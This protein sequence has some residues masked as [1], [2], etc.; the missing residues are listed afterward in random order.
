MHKPN[1][2]QD[3]GSDAGTANTNKTAQHPII[4][5]MEHPEFTPE[6]LPELWKQTK[7]P[8]DAHGGQMVAWGAGVETLYRRC[9]T[10]PQHTKIAV[11]L[12]GI[13]P[14]AWH[15]HTPW[16]D[17]GWAV[18]Q[19]DDL[20]HQATP[21]QILQALAHEQQHP[22]G[23]WRASDHILMWA[24]V[25]QLTG[26]VIEQLPWKNQLLDYATT[27]EQ[28]QATETTDFEQVRSRRRQHIVEHIQQRLLGGDN[29]AWTVFLGIV[30]PGAN[31]GDTAEIA[32]AVE[33]GRRPCLHKA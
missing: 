30:E 7:G 21:E 28:N 1:Q 8:D 18:A 26:P 27:A 3:P 17:T 20:A 6:Q 29:N 11:I 24:T 32:K 2:K 4:A 12:S 31:V 23:W 14:N 25:A 10:Y 13:P 5:A 9:E 22:D 15:K 16:H 19:A 33:Q